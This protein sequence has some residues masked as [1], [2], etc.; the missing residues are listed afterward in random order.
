MY[1]T[2]LTRDEETAYTMW[3]AQQ[4][5]AGNILPDDWGQDYDFRGYWKETQ[6]QGM[7]T[8]ETHFTDKYKKP[9]HPTFSNESIYSTGENAMYAGYWLGEEFVAP[10]IRYQPGTMSEM[11]NDIISR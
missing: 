7:S 1:D 5:N 6:G 10:L 11:I 4:K 8:A 2:E 9:N 3:M